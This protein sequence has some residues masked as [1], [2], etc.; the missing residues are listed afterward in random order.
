MLNCDFHWSNRLF[1]LLAVLFSFFNTSALA[2]PTE[3]YITH[4]LSNAANEGEYI[5]NIKFDIES[6]W[7][8]YGPTQPNALGRPL[9]IDLANSLN[10]KNWQINWPKAEQHTYN[11]PDIQL[12]SNIYKNSVTV[13]ISIRVAN[14]K[15]PATLNVQINYSL[16]KEV[17]TQ[18]S[19]HFQKMI[20]PTANFYSYYSI[21]MLFAI[22]A[23]IILNFMPCV[24]PVLMLKLL[25]I[26]RYSAYPKLLIRQHL[27]ASFLG[28]LAFFLVLGIITASLQASHQP[29]EWGQHF[30]SP[31]LLM[32][33]CLFLMLLISELKGEITLAAPTSL[34]NFASPQQHHSSCL[35]SFSAGA[36]SAILASSCTA[37]FLAASIAF[38]FTQ[39]W[40]IIIAIYLCIGFGMA[41]PYLFLMIWPQWV[42]SLL[43]LQRH[44]PKIIK[45]LLVM[46][47][48]TIIWLLSL[49]INLLPWQTSAVFIGCLIIIRAILSHGSIMQ[50]SFS[51]QD[52]ALLLMIAIPIALSLTM[53]RLS[54][55]ENDIAIP[56]EG[57]SI[58][59]KI[60]QLQQSGKTVLVYVSAN[61]CLTCKVNEVMVLERADVRK[62]LQQHNVVV[63]KLDYTIRIPAITQFLQHHHHYGIPF[64]IVYGVNAQNG[65]K[66]PSIMVSDAELKGAIIKSMKK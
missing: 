8:L 49:I 52:T 50:K 6:G 4:T 1:I 43:Q 47:V 20:I 63:M 66:L 10:V 38:A 28:V 55:F 24:L 33:I 30:Q 64:A 59:D 51:K 36:L 7:Q 65:I 12:I 14:T 37:P 45:I 32:L 9:N 23:G 22:L 29:V 26:I 27:G 40:H 34:Q 13:P 42:S 46:L 15:E 54:K 44:M 5:L 25:G 56:P 35:A 3:V 41:I 39:P 2:Q 16:C 61:W 18:G 19:A 53:L 17:C 58:Q 62:W 11:L 21:M 60:L 48:L 31:I 57:I